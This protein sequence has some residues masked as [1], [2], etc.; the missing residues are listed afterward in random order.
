MSLDYAVDRQILHLTQIPWRHCDRKSQWPERSAPDDS[1]MA[2]TW[3]WCSHR[4]L[5]MTRNIRRI[6]QREDKSS[7][8]TSPEET[9]I[10]KVIGIMHCRL[11]EHMRCM[12]L[13]IWWGELELEHGISFGVLKI[14]SYSR[15]KVWYCLEWDDR[16]LPQR[17][18]LA[19]SLSW[20]PEARFD[21]YSRAV[22]S[23]HITL[24]TRFWR[25]LNQFPDLL[26][27]YHKNGIAGPFRRSQKLWSWGQMAPLLYILCIVN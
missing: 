21:N 10:P 15:G 19:L 4:D 2:N 23:V 22:E 18:R 16:P 17:G 14:W 27:Q 13:Q 12:Y 26:W 8:N 20:E 24:S 5:Q 3:D 25:K 11:D 7:R 6:K 1:E 9:L